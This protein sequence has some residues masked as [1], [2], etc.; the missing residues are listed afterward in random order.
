VIY[1]KIKKLISNDQ[2]VNANDLTKEI[3]NFLNSSESS[4]NSAVEDILSLYIENFENE[5]IRDFFSVGFHFLF[6]QELT[7]NN[8]KTFEVYTDINRTEK[9]QFV[10]LNFYPIKDLIKKSFNDYFYHEFNKNSIGLREIANKAFSADLIDYKHLKD[11]CTKLELSKNKEFLQDFMKSTRTFSQMELLS[12]TLK[13]SP[14]VIISKDKE[15][16]TLW[17][18]YVWNME[19]VYGQRKTYFEYK[20]RLFSDIEEWNNLE[21]PNT[22]KLDLQS[23]IVFAASHVNNERFLS[24]FLKRTNIK[25]VNLEC[26]DYL[27]NPNKKMTLKECLLKKGKLKTVNKFEKNKNTKTDLAH[28]IT[29]LPDKPDL[30]TNKK[31]F[32]KQWV[33]GIENEI[34]YTSI[35][36]A[37]LKTKRRKPENRPVTYVQIEISCYLPVNAEY[38]DK[39]KQ[40]LESKKNKYNDR[41]LLLSFDAYRINSAFISFVNLASWLKDKPINWKL[42]TNKGRTLLAESIITCMQSPDIYY[43]EP[44]A[45]SDSTFIQ[46]FKNLSKEDKKEVFAEIVD[47]WEEIWTKEISNYYERY[48]INYPFEESLVFR[49]MNELLTICI[50]EDI[51]FDKSLFNEQWK[52]IKNVFEKYSKN[53]KVKIFLSSAEVLELNSNLSVKNSLLRNKFN[54]IKL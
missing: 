13:I 51:K 19:L 16:E 10:D 4:L 7:W 48:V 37:V 34:D 15:I 25:N 42:I 12:S 41:E 49:F 9:R 31:A 52:E 27:V 26:V 50:N 36:N 47:S 53:E 5:K 11:V 54:K 22:S 30:I 29:S 28:I 21:T 43:L 23:R 14:W 46:A 3:Y 24:W 39:L 20:E 1:Q 17:P 40:H 35:L 6:S 32:L 8:L 38:L 18:T 45:H 44:L 2:L 33:K